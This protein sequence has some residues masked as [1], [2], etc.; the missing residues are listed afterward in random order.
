M[1]KK[2]ET[3]KLEEM[4]IIEPIRNPY[5]EGWQVLKKKQLKKITINY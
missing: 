2:N 1:F 3:I 4:P 5:I